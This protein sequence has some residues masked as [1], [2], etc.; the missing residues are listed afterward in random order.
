[1]AGREVIPAPIALWLA[2][3][4]AKFVGVGL[5]AAV[6]V[7]FLAGIYSYGKAAGTHACEMKQ[8]KTETAQVIEAAAVDKAQTQD[9]AQAEIRYVERIVTVEKRVPVVRDR[10]VRVCEQALPVR[11]GAD[12]PQVSG[13]GDG[14]GETDPADR[15]YDVDQLSREILTCRENAEAHRLLRETAIAN[16]ALM[17]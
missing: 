17:P 8:A 12:V 5:L 13:P 9:V 2:K 6:L 7:S 3:P 10:L 1:M 15:L 11:G 4:A 14:G 16:G